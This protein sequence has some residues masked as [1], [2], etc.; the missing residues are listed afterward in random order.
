MPLKELIHQC[1]EIVSNNESILFGETKETKSHQDATE[2]IRQLNRRDMIKLVYDPD[3]SLMEQ[4]KLKA[5]GIPTEDELRK[6]VKKESVDLEEP[7][8]GN[9]AKSAILPF[10]HISGAADPDQ[11]ME[12]EKSQ[13]FY[14]RDRLFTV[15]GKVAVDVLHAENLWMVEERV[16]RIDTLQ[17]AKDY[18]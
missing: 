15:L 4:A 6:V 11:P 16:K 10:S 18:S 14:K 2:A 5:Q 17:K 1:H 9:K 3:G 12:E 8:L 7:V 13:I